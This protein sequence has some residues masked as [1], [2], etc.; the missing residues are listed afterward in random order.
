[1]ATTQST[2]VESTDAQTIDCGDCAE[3]PDDFPCATCYINGW[4][5]FDQ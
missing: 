1:M 2:L 4:A 5:D 3:L